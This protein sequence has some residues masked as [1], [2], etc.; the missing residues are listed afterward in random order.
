MLLTASLAVSQTQSEIVKM[1]Q[2]QNTEKLEVLSRAT[3]K[4]KAKK[5]EVL[6]KANQKGLKVNEIIDGKLH[7]IV[8]FYNDKPIYQT[9]H[10]IDASSSTRANFLWQDGNLG[11]NIEGQNML[12][13]VWDEQRVKDDHV[14]F[15][16]SNGE[17][18]II[19]GDANAFTEDQF[20]DHGTHVG[21]TI[22]AAGLNPSAK[23]AAP[24]SSIVTYTWDS[25]YEE[26]QDEI[27]DN[28]LL[29]SNHSYGIPVFSNS[30]QAPTWLMGNYSSQARFWDLVA[31]TYPY[32][33]MVV[34]A[35]NDG[36]SNYTG[37]LR[38]GFDKLTHEKN[39]K[40]N[41]VIGNAQDASV[42]SESGEL[43]FPAFINSSSSQGPSDDGR[44][45]PDVV[46]NGTQVFSTITTSINSYAVFSGTSMA[47]PNVAGTL[48][49]LQQYYNQEKSN[50]MLSSTLKALAIH[51]ADDLGNTGPDA[52]YGWGLINAKKAAELI[53]NTDTDEARIEEFDLENNDTFTFNVKKENSKN[54]EV[55]IV[56]NDPA[57]TARDAQLNNASPAL[58][59]DLDL[60]ITNTATDETYFPWKLD[61]SNVSASATKADNIVDNVEN[62]IVDSDDGDIYE[63]TI[64]HKGS[65]NNPQKVSLIVS[66]V[67]YTT[68]ATQDVEV[69]L[70]TINLWPNPVKNQLNITG[71][72]AFEGQAEVKVYDL[73]GRL[74]LSSTKDSTSQNTIQINT[75]SLSTGTYLVKITDGKTSLNKKIIKE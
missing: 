56:W 43:T 29:I 69:D 51:T 49:L 13:G 54:L 37:G 25:D 59:N 31:N 14:E 61:L 9:A 10:N 3:E 11:L 57:G 27:I 21:G 71:V 38:N 52:K 50:Y 30:G 45:K 15:I 40:N 5:L 47:A 28:G 73:S 36:Q 70:S 65:L 75:S 39:S 35:G 55:T 7:T 1:N 74:V 62:I 2:L 4:L 48:I 66:G 72:E 46:G 6:K 63:V 68:L 20:G 64:S 41:L 26:V 18:R 16:D 34:S 12:V 58:I 32:Y 42:D 53:Q 60:R 19:L 24:Q 33:L 44:I 23:G 17:T 22:G 67:E 8:D